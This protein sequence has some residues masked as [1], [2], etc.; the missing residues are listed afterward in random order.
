MKQKENRIWSICLA[1]P[2]L[3]RA[4]TSPQFATFPPAGYLFSRHNQMGKI[5]WTFRAIGKTASSLSAQSTDSG[6]PAVKT[7]VSIFPQSQ[8]DAS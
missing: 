4:Q 1:D 8:K 5:L 2:V 3:K 7:L 6:N